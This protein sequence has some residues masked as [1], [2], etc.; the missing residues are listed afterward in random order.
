MEAHER[1]R[2]ARLAARY[3]TATEAAEAFGW[4][5]SAYI[6]HENGQRGL[7]PDVA[8][9]Y[10]KAYKVPVEW[11]LYER[12]PQK[13]QPGEA[14]PEI[15]IIGYV[16]AGSETRFYNDVREEPE[17]RTVPAPRG[18]TDETVAVE[19]RGESLGP[20]FDRAIVF[21]NDVRRPATDDLVGRLCVVGL[22]DGRIVVKILRR[23]KSQRGLFH[24]MSN[25]SEPP[26]L[27]AKIEWAA[28]VIDVRPH[29]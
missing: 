20:A 13:A 17:P 6:S 16:A 11:L 19:V 21:Y 27:D 12:G 24:L 7:R 9:R 18:A 8:A 28:R 23:S 15:P 10:A 1:L 3:E 14:P 29:D 22:D 25:G 4:P 2:Q 5:K 26:I